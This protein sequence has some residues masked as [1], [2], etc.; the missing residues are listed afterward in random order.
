MQS[1]STLYKTMLAG[2]AAREVKVEVYDKNGTASSKKTYTQDE[3]TSCRRTA[4]AYSDSAPVPGGCVSA[5]LDLELYTTDTIP[6]MA[7]IK[8]FCRLNDGITTSEWIP[9]GVFYVDTREVDTEAGLITLEAVDG[10]RKADQVYQLEGDTGEWPRLMS[11]VVSDICT[12]C[13]YSLDGRT[14][15]SS[16]YK[17]EYPNDYTMREI[18]GYIA[19]AHGGFWTMAG[20]GKL[21]LAQ[22]W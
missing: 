3:I 14:S 1:T 2:S 12:R 19:A 22:L 17:M 8:L 4:S 15:L 21:R 13:G 6:E 5:T 20:D 16:T 11:T 10:L 7:M 9:Q 18:L